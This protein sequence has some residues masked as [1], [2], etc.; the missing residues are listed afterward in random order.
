MGNFAVAASDE[1]IRQGNELLSE[2]SKDGVKKEIALSRLFEMARENFDGHTLKQGGLDVQ[3]LDATLANI[4]TMFLAAVTGKEQIVL[5]KDTQ[6]AE[7]KELKDRMET[8]M[9]AK[10]T[11]AQDAKEQ[12]EKLASE[13]QKIGKQAEKDAAAAK[14]Q[15]DTASSLVAEKQKI[16]DMLSAKLAEAEAKIE[17][18]DTL[19]SELEEAQKKISE[20]NRTIAENQKTAEYEKTVLKAEMDRK[21]SEQEKDAALNLERAMSSKEKEKSEVILELQKQNAVLQA[22]IEMLTE[23]SSMQID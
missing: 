12:A 10:I 13:A 22:K 19:R 3:A 17:N 1:V 11:V 21:L 23:K 18:Y 15:A 5:E 14:E 8:D 2:L 9:R 16:N 6:I 4:R 7:I 20:L